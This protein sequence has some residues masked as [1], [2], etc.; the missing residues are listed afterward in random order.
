[1]ILDCYLAFVAELE[2]VL[3]D[4]HL[5]NFQD[6]WKEID[7]EGTGRASVWKLRQL[8]ERLHIEGNPM[9]SC[10]L[11]DEIKHRAIRM[12]IVEGCDD[13]MMEFDRV[14]RVL[15]LDVA[16]PKALPY[17]EMLSY[18]SSRAFFAQA[19]LLGHVAQN[20]CR[21][22]FRRDI[23]M[24]RISQEL[25]KEEGQMEGM[26][27]ISRW[28][29]RWDE[30]K[31]RPVCTPNILI[32]KENQGSEQDCI[33]ID[34]DRSI[35]IKINSPEKVF[36]SFDD[37]AHIGKN[38]IAKTDSITS[39]YLTDPFAKELLR[40]TIHLADGRRVHCNFADSY[41][42]A[43]FGN[44]MSEII[45]H[46]QRTQS[47]FENSMSLSSSSTNFGIQ[48][49]DGDVNVT[50]DVRA[51]K[52]TWNSS[53]HNAALGSLPCELVDHGIDLSTRLQTQDGIKHVLKVTS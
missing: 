50:T 30:R 18:Q 33:M 13:H 34:C 53:D 10:G 37:I 38:E 25:S 39:R 40:V 52:R 9:G 24:G 6:K 8:L 26:E 7:P 1:V 17:E 44:L 49:D 15:A 22:K 31:T 45:A 14:V 11:V 21:R 41:E 51:L 46:H 2:F 42:G 36:L 47:K 32:F 3:N 48:Q 16:G 29:Y 19:A 27:A 23:M 43:M 12:E 20:F 28:L 4:N 5:E 35:L